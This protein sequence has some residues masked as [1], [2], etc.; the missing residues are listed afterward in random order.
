M[1]RPKNHRS[2]SAGHST[3]WFSLTSLPDSVHGNTAL[4]DS[5]K[6]SSKF[7]SPDCS[8]PS[9]SLLSLPDP[10]S[11]LEDAEEL[12]ELE[13]PD[14][15]WLEVSDPEAEPEELELS[16]SSLLLLS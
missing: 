2:R 6:V 15:E 14:E 13:P 4:S 7:S 12:D 5:Q 11:E 10:L 1:H 9:S 3:W 8:P 16:S